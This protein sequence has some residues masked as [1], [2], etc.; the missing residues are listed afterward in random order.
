MPSRQESPDFRRSLASTGDSEAIHRRSEID[1]SGGFRKPR[2]CHAM[3]ETASTPSG[4]TPAQDDTLTLVPRD[5]RG[6]S[7]GVAPDLRRVATRLPH[8]AAFAA[9]TAE[10]SHA[11]GK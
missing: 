7:A 3:M 2:E 5:R 6:A 11:T 1:R 4:A 9:T 10:R 8:H